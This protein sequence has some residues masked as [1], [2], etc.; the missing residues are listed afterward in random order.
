MKLRFRT[1]RLTF[2][3]TLL[4]CISCILDVESTEQVSELM[5][6][7]KTILAKLFYAFSL[8]DLSHLKLEVI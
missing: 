3:N 6:Q 1:V 4:D 8:Q 5:E 2:N 7:L